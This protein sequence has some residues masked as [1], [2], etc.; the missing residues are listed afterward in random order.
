MFR[1]KKPAPA[2]LMSMTDDELAAYNK[3]KTKEFMIT[4]TIIISGIITSVVLSTA[5]EKAVDKKLEA[6]YT[7]R[8][9]N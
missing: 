9:E 1:T 4:T 2:V 8:I 3:S 7:A 6:H 5:I